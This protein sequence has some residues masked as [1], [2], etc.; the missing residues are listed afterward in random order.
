MP[1]YLRSFRCGTLGDVWGRLRRFA[2]RKAGFSPSVFHKIRLQ[3][4]N[5]RHAIIPQCSGRDLIGDVKLTKINAMR[6]ARSVLIVT[7]ALF[8]GAVSAQVNYDL[9]PGYGTKHGYP[10]TVTYRAWVLSFRD[11]K[12]YGCLATYDFVTPA[13]PTLTCRPAGSF[14]P[15]LMSGAHVKTLQAPGGPPGGIGSEE[16]LSVFFWQIDQATGQIQFCIPVENINC[17]A[18]QIP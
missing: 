12:F 15:P 10:P 11:N 2:L 18:F 14:E 17:V 13:T 9:L 16:I 4:S 8:S 3:A 7:G 6:S 1:R 5:L